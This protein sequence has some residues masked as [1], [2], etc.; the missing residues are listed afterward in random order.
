MHSS[1]AEG[2]KPGI[3]K[4][5]ASGLIFLEAEISPC[6]WTRCLWSF[7]HA[8]TG[9]CPQSEL[10]DFRV[11]KDL[12]GRTVQL[13]LATGI[14]AKASLLNNCRTIAWLFPVMGNSPLMSSTVKRL[15]KV[16]LFF[17]RAIIDLN[18]YPLI[19]LASSDATKKSFQQICPLF[20]Q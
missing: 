1:N 12:R 3:F 9:K 20:Q 5:S 19:L 13:F 2:G 14:H 4:V 6:M 10:R 7:P 16:S 8:T 18:F 11:G 15:Y 17:C